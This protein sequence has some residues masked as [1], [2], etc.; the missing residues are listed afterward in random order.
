MPERK[1]FISY[2]HE[3]KAVA[4]R[5]AHALNDDGVDVWWD[6]WELQPGDSLV[7]KIFESGLSQASHFLILLSP[8]SVR[9][10]WVREELDVATVRR[11]EDLVRVI[12]V[13]I[14]DTDIPTPLRALL[15]V[16]LRNDFDGGV[17]RI[18]NVVHEI[19][20]KPPR[21]PAPT[22]SAVE[23]LPGLSRAA[24][25]VGNL[26]VAASDAAAPATTA[27]LNSQLAEQLRMDPSILND[28]VDELEDGG[29]V[30]VLRTIGTGPYRFYQIEPTYVLFREFRSRLGY[31]PDDDVRQ[32]AAAV[33]ARSQ[34]RGNELQETT[35]L[36]PARINRAADY[37]DDYGLAQVGRACG[38]SPFNFS[39]LQAT[40]RTR[41]FVEGTG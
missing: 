17:Q 25:A 21:A 7:S 23:A 12:P 40:H 11:I 15:W 29:L 18:S 5:L 16:D 6:S 22:L 36:D 8:D 31:D 3:D 27:I 34:V 10:R 35:K 39:W 14:R 19:S 9:S 38:T 24:T 20:T 4:E 37:I 2:S 30:R 41:Q 32:V 13:L 28:A 26:L 1:V 33:T